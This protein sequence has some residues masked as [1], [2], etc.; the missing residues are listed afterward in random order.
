MA[1]L[2]LNRPGFLQIAGM[3]GEGGRVADSV[4]FCLDGPH[5]DST[6]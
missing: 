1:G 2:T 3:A 6:W 4:I 5:I